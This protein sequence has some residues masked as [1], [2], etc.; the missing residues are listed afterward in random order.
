MTRRPTHARAAAAAWALA[1]LATALPAAA[2][3]DLTMLAMTSNCLNCH[4]IDQAS[5][6][7]PSFQAIARRYKG[8]KTAPDRLAQK[9]LKGGGGVWGSKKMDPNEVSPQDARR[10]A[11]WILRTP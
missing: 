3:E 9:I 1:S 6:D 5:E 8:D 4:A 2:A 10:L 7:G 11:E